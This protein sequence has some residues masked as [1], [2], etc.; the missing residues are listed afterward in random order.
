MK[1]ITEMVPDVIRIYI[2]ISGRKIAPN[3]SEL[4]GPPPIANTAKARM[5]ILKNISNKKSIESFKIHSL[6]TEAIK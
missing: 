3:K 6:M 4:Q 2:F 5:D 1:L